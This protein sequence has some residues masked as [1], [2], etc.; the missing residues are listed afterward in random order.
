[1]IISFFHVLAVDTEGCMW[2]SAQAFFGSEPA[3]F[4]TYAVGRVVDAY[5]GCLQFLYEVKLSL[6]HAGSFFF[7]QGV[8]ALFKHFEC[9]GSVGSIVAF[10]VVP[11]FTQSVIFT[12][13]FFQFGE[14]ELTK[15]LKFFVAVSGSVGGIQFLM[16]VY[17][18][19]N[20]TF[21]MIGVPS[22]TSVSS[23]AEG[24]T[25]ASSSLFAST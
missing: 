2:Y 14:Y 18:L 8:C 16:C 20:V 25:G 6:G 9:G 12:L 15:F 24:V 19:S 1:M 17:G 3:G 7:P 21:T 4:P 23:S 13:G 5:E 11:F 10:T 22:M